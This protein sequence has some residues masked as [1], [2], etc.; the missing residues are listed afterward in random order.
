MARMARWVEGDGNVLG[1]R[2]RRTSDYCVSLVSV[3]V[4]PTWVSFKGSPTQYGEGHGPPASRSMVG[5]K[6]GHDFSIEGPPTQYERPLDVLVPLFD[7]YPQSADFRENEVCTQGVRTRPQ[8]VSGAYA[9][10]RHRPGR[11]FVDYLVFGLS[12]G[13]PH[14]L[15]SQ[16]TAVRASSAGLS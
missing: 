14:A 15:C 16:Q 4:G 5:C 11:E 10:T 3:H 8:G 12:E 7:R 9:S 13:D 1:A 6:P 2:C